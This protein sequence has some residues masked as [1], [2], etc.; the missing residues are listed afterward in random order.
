MSRYKISLTAERAAGMTVNE[1]LW[2]AG[3]MD[4]FDSAVEKMDW[5]RLSEILKPVYLDQ[6][7]IDAIITSQ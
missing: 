2:I 7:S 1:R 4:D 3:L 6:E 5:D